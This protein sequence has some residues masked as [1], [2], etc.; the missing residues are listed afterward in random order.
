MREEGTCWGAWRRR[1]GQLGWIW[2]TY[3]VLLVYDCQSVRHS[4]FFPQVKREANKKPR[5]REDAEGLAE[6]LRMRAE[7]LP[8]VQQG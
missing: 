7:A 3:I 8:D 4:F 5:A 6:Q 1:R 2:P